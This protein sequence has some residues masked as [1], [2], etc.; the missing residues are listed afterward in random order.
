M[1][2]F[3][4]TT[5]VRIYM[6][7]KQISIKIQLGWKNG[8]IT[9]MFWIE[10]NYIFLMELRADIGGLV[11]E[12]RNFIANALELRLSWTNSSIYS[13]TIALIKVWMKSILQDNV[14]TAV[15]FSATAVAKYISCQICNRATKSWFI[16][17]SVGDIPCLVR[18]SVRCYEPFIYESCN[19]LQWCHNEHDVISNHQRLDCL[20]NHLFRS[21][22]KKTS[23]L[24]VTGLCEG[25]SPVT[26]EFPS[27]R[28]SDTK[29]ASIW[30]CHH[31]QLNSIDTSQILMWSSTG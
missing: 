7:G 5:K 22:S 28:T 17:F 16:N 13:K 11:Q 18:V 12:K 24:C 15:Y 29:N 4:V 14:H 26:I 19:S 27:Q 21:K 23:K 8:Q 1:Q 6:K 10:K 31:V 25:N 2:K 3:A 9:V 20:L 30:W